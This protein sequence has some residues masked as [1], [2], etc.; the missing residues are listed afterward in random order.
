MLHN[1][2][3]NLKTYFQIYFRKVGWRALY[4]R[5][6]SNGLL[7]LSLP[8]RGLAVGCQNGHTRFTFMEVLNFQDKVLTEKKMLN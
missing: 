4:P 8:D 5:P 3:E 2:K 6:Q 7:Y 1:F